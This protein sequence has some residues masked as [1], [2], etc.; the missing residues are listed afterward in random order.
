MSGLM[1]PAPMETADTFMNMPVAAA[2]DIARRGLYLPSNPGAPFQIPQHL[3]SLDD[4]ALGDVLNQANIWCGY[5]ESELAQAKT[6]RDA[7]ETRRDFIRA[8]V[9]MQVRAGA[10]KKLSNPD[11]DDNVE[12][13]PRVAQAENDLLF[14]EARYAYIKVLVNNAQRDWDTISRHITQR[15]QEIDRHRRGDNVG[16]TQVPMHSGTF[17]R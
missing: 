9:R 14:H 2:E 12:T 6:F 17:R 5:V 16:Q 11:K 7:A 8:K 4:R 3:A 13:D 15:G 10:E 1:Q